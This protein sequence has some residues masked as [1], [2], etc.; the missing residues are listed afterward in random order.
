MKTW[1]SAIASSCSLR[2]IIQNQTYINV[3]VSRC[4][5][6]H[7]DPTW[8]Y[9]NMIYRNNEPLFSGSLALLWGKQNT[10]NAQNYVYISLGRSFC[11]WFF[12][13]NH[14][15]LFK[16][17]KCVINGARIPS[18]VMSEIVVEIEFLEAILCWKLVWV[19]ILYEMK[20]WS[21]CRVNKAVIRKILWVYYFGVF[22]GRNYN[23]SQ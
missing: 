20:G 19:G 18:N 13:N 12:N 8:I 10:S 15:K 9:K 17:K 21:L 16:C 7:P 2:W 14:Q 11:G 1:S 4:Y 5:G 22:V 23:Y 3:F 6:S